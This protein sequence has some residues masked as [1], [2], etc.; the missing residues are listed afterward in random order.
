MRGWIVAAVIALT[1]ITSTAHAYV[2]KRNDS[3]LPEY[4][5]ASC[6]SVTVYTNGFSMM[7]RDEIAKSIGAA[8]Q[9]WSPGA[10]SCPDGGHPSIEI[11]T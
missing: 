4:W 2:Q 7:T 11:V 1:I 8:A 6:A 3:G 5:Q 9:A 10:V